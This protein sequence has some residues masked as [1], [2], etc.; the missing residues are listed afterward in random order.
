MKC[1]LFPV[2]RECMEVVTICL[3][4]GGGRLEA[5][6]NETWWQDAALFLMIDCPNPQA[7]NLTVNQYCKDNSSGLLNMQDRRTYSVST[8]FMFE[9]VLLR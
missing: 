3:A 2:V 1:L 6:L 5:L 4:L 8:C 9:N 7:S